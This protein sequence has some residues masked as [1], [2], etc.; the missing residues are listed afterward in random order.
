MAASVDR[1]R[2]PPPLEGVRVLDLSVIWAG[3]YATRLLADL[4][5][6]VIKVE[7]LSFYDIQRGPVAPTRGHIN[8]NYPDGDPG[9]E[10]WNRSAWFNTLHINKLDVTL[11]LVEETGR[12]L[13]LRLAA[14]SDVVIENFRYGIREKRL[15]LSYE[16][17]RQARPDIILASMPAFGNSGPWRGYAQYGIGQE[18]LAGFPS[19]TGHSPDQP[20]KSGINHGDPI[21]GIHAAS[22]I[23][24]AL[25]RRR[26]T[27]KGAFIDLSQQESTISFIGEHLLGYQMTGENPQPAGNSHPAMSPHGVFPCRGK[28]RWVAVAVSTDAQWQTLCESMGQSDLA[29]HPD[30]AN[31]PMRWQNREDLASLVSQWTSQHDAQEIASRLQATGVAASPVNSPRELF[32]DPHYLARGFF[33]SVDHPSTGPRDYPGFPFRLSKSAME[34]RRPA[35]TLGEHNRQVLGTLL[36]LTDEALRELEMAGIIG[37]KPYETERSRSLG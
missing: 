5:A 21:T 16:R 10:P 18:M 24:A 28:D 29:Q 36:G 26:R 22:A 11:D 27:G 12:D 7:A 4:G 25:L 32:R 9:D 19:M 35:P 33:E 2:L 8:L 3:P 31:A 13:L 14:V 23:L 1:K 34:I 37:D 30:Y 15:G 17:L 20:A 6:E